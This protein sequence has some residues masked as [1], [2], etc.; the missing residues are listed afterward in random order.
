M[1]ES[2]VDNE[3][4]CL[5]RSLIVLA[6][7]CLLVLFELLYSDE[8]KKAFLMDCG[9]TCA[10][11]LRGFQLRMTIASMDVQMMMWDDLL[12]M[13]VSRC[14]SMRESLLAVEKMKKIRNRKCM[15]EITYSDSMARM[16]FRCLP[17]AL[18]IIAIPEWLKDNAWGLQKCM[19]VI[20]NYNMDIFY[21]HDDADVI[22]FFLK[23]YTT[24]EAVMATPCGL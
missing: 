17:C 22:C 2:H 6:W 21:R 23:D 7:F 4:M 12:T 19:H 18:A 10:H 13:V 9:G 15:P 20:Y 14:L 8:L 16:A 24:K 5:L 3:R 1:W 11:F